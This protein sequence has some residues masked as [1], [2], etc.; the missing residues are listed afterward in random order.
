MVFWKPSRRLGF[1]GGV[2]LVGL[3]GCAVWPTSRVPAVPQGAA[4]EVVA[5][6]APAVAEPAPSPQP[7]SAEPSV[8][9]P[10]AP[11]ISAP[12]PVVAP[13]APPADSSK[14]PIATPPAPGTTSAVPPLAP[15]AQ[16]EAGP[17]SGSPS[18]AETGP[19]AESNHDQLG[20][21]R[22]LDLSSPG[23]NPA[24]LNQSNSGQPSTGVTAPLPVPPAPAGSSQPSEGSKSDKPLSP[25]ARLKARFHR[26]VQ[27]A[28]KPPQKPINTDKPAE[29]VVA[30]P[31]VTVRIPLPTSNETQIAQQSSPT[32]HGLY[33]ADEDSASTMPSGPGPQPGVVPAGQAQAAGTTP[34]GARSASAAPGEIEQWPYSPQSAVKT[35][36]SSHTPAPSSDF[37]P[38][39]VEE[40]RAALA[41]ATGDSNPLPAFQ[42]K[43]ANSNASASPAVAATTT[44]Q[45]H[46]VPKVQGPASESRPTL[47]PID[48]AE[49]HAAVGPQSTLPEPLDSQARDQS[50]Q[51]PPQIPPA[52][53]SA[54]APATPVGSTEGVTPAVQM[55]A[56][57]PAQVVPVRSPQWIGG[58]YGQPAWM[59]VPAASPTSN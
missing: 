55:S 46:D 11:S 51:G 7:G 58:R 24:D 52:P 53:P 14:D 9:A 50:Q 39:P 15:P 8:D 2:A 43:S 41:K 47:I 59:S 27:P 12:G 22:P 19:A 35:A 6:P 4:A 42:Q 56:T 26:L 16:P 3:A 48:Q 32:V 17:I 29:T 21:Q 40:Y 37:D 38:M 44:A 34:A 36:E 57:A 23:S 33:P 20:P 10:G 18:P 5:T 25:L 45:L 30:P 1:L 13:P 54:P 31:A 28:P 49:S